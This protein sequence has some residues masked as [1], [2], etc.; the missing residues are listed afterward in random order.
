[1][2]LQVRHKLFHFEYSISIFII[3]INN[4]F[5][6]INTCQNSDKF[7]QNFNIY[8]VKNVIKYIYNIEREISWN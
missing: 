5:E 3:K 8:F 2:F 6:I 1:M 7:W 4:C